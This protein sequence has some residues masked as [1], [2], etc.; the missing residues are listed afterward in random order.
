MPKQTADRLISK[1][2]VQ[3]KKRNLKDAER[4]YNEVLQNYPGN[5]RARKGLAALRAMV[6][7]SQGN[8]GPDAEYKNL[9]SLFEGRDYRAAID[10]AEDLLSKH[11][12]ASRVWN[13]LGAA[14][15]A[16]GDVTAAE[17]SYLRACECNPRFAEAFYN[18]GNVL[19]KQMRHAEAIRAYRRALDVKPGYTA[20]LNNLG[21]SLMETGAI[22]ESISTFRRA[23]E[24]QPDFAVALN[25]LGNALRAADQADQA[26]SAYRRALQFRPDY[27]DVYNNLGNALR[28][29]KRFDES[30]AAFHHALKL[31]PIYATAYENLGHAFV[32]ARRSAEA[33][34][35]YQMS[36]K[37]N[38]S[39]PFVFNSIGKLLQAQGRLDEAVSSYRTALRI[40]P[41]F[42][43]AEAQMLHQLQ[44]MC[45]FSAADEISSAC[46]RFRYETRASAP[47]TALA[48]ADDPD[49][50]LRRSIAWSREKYGIAEAKIPE[51]PSI[52][53][54][55][56]KLGYFSADFHD[57]ATMF[58]L[59]GVLREHDRSSFEVFAYSYGRN[60]QGKLRKK[61]EEYVDHFFDVSELT[62]SAIAEMVR[63]HSLDIAIDLK[64][65]T[66]ETQSG[67][68]RFRLA[69]VQ[70]NYLGY[71]GTM[72]ADFIDYLIGDPVVIPSDQ[73]GYYTESLIYMPHSYQPN[74]D[75]R[76][77]AS[78]VGCRQT[79][80]LPG[81]AFVLCCFNNN[82][83][84]GRAEFRIWMR[85][86]RSNP[87]SV[88]WLMQSNRWA[89]ENLRREAWAC[90][91][92]PSR[93][94]FAGKVSHAE[95]LARHRH[96][97]LF[98]DTFN[99]NA[100]TTASDALWASLPV[101]T[102]Q[103]SQFAARVAASL[104]TAAGL[105]ELIA[106]DDSEYERIIMEL[107]NCREK[108]TSLK[109]KLAQVHRSALFDTRRYTRNL[110]SGFRR[111][112]DAYY[113][114][115]ARSDIWVQDVGCSG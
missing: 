12:E 20:A 65:Y 58:L 90:G 102:K 72:G 19:K 96:A 82:Y 101:V 3:A 23:V 47:F 31:K 32:D 107:V 45:D 48:W 27:A 59:A 39:N 100:H 84:I 13:I 109:G 104:L 1:A 106:R 6:S 34:A 53:P 15:I 37:I 67:I 97:D 24:I 22:E 87:D 61:A 14:Q 54:E 92:D 41:D 35:S 42:P 11:P 110:E 17:A 4:L 91:V 30:I 44:H 86:L 49:L 74:D 88:L 5:V 75:E 46:E 103:G 43:E 25:N 78:E 66:R 38:P 9:L 89:E 62:E 60:R 99:Y 33:L 115:K 16:L 77:I 81:N 21:T 63:A 28:Q 57:H 98:I 40:K 29:L 10:E 71:P 113:L 114:G 108:L 112:Y 80:N 93:L 8:E 69:P 83:K 36:A 79:Y 70:V 76:Q 73:R 64:G 55:R 111:A 85:I 51:R 56:L 2:E 94:V 26:V 52:Y 50:Q 18:L 105:P 68:L 7:G 95:H